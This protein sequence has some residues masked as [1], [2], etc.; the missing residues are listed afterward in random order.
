[1]KKD[2]ETFK[3]VCD[4]VNHLI[5]KG[6]ATKVPD[7]ELEPKEG[8]PTFYLPLIAVKNP[9]KPGV[10]LCKD[11][12]AL[13]D[14]VSL[15]SAILSGPDNANSLLGVLLR[16]RQDPFVLMADLQEFFLQLRVTPED[17]N[18]LRFYFWKDNDLS[19]PL[20]VLK[21]LSH[22][23]GLTSSPA[24]A[25]YAVKHLGEMNREF[26]P[27]DVILTII[28]AFFVDDLQK[29]CPDRQTA[30][31]IMES[32]IEIF[33]SVGMSLTKWMTNDP[34]ILAA[35]PEE[36]R[37]P[38]VKEQGLGDLPVQRALGVHYDLNSDCFVFKI[39]NLQLPVRPLSRR[40][41]L[42]FL[43]SI[44]TP[45]GFLVAIL[46]VAKKIL[47]KLSA[48]QLSWD[49]PVPQEEEQKF[50]E[51]A[52]SLTHLQDVK[53]P[54][55]Y[56]NKIQ[57]KIVS[58]Q[59]HFCSDSANEDK[60]YGAICYLRKIDEAG[61]I[62]TSLVT[63][64]SRVAPLKMQHETQVFGSVPKL[65][66]CAAV[67]S[68][69]LYLFVK[70]EL[71]IEVDSVHFWVD[72]TCVLR[73]IRSTTAR[74]RPFVFNRISKIR[75]VTD[76]SQWHYCDTEKNPADLVSRGFMANDKE[77]WNFFLSGGF[78]ALPE[79]EWP[80]DPILDPLE[81]AEVAATAVEPPPFNL[82][83][84]VANRTSKWYKLLKMVCWLKRFKQFIMIKC[85]ISDCILAGRRE[86]E[87]VRKK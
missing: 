62:H 38:S 87:N 53:I 22:L 56:G 78:V 58:N 7:E 77:S 74:H 8:E 40:I 68:V 84:E 28:R 25:N 35:I 45:I 23:F 59:L 39:D 13:A 83:L 27:L 71:E 75:S 31:R 5:E 76:A 54:R 12:K 52:D 17:T 67:V 79:A 19:Q 64:K 24:I 21:M 70:N 29:S 26:Y 73:W 85:K 47:Q 81:E 20:E 2:P 57:G 51:W 11:A 4:K 72:S 16:F 9:N 10:R 86:V 80:E 48:M 55:W 42:S 41:M 60:G 34:E 32:L 6:Y 3:M 50:R 69:D 66:L 30:I 1:M 37:A 36:L 82:I 49:E 65:E 61:T 14:G 33:R 44:Y 63:A 15:N 46:L 43:A 18:A